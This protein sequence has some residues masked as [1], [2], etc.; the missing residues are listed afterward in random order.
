[1]PNKNEFVPYAMVSPGSE[2]V[3]SGQKRETVTDDTDEHGH[4]I[5]RWSLWTWTGVELEW[6]REIQ[7]INAMQQSLGPLDDET[8]RFRAHIASW[9][10]CDSGFPVTVDELLTAIGRG[11]LDEEPFHNG[12]F[13]SAG[14]KSTQPHQVESLRAIEEILRDYLAGKDVQDEVARF[15]YARGFIERAYQWLGPVDELSEVQRLLLQRVLLPFE[16]LTGRNPDQEAVHQ[17]CFGEDGLGAQLDAQ[18]A[19][20]AG[21]PR[22]HANYTREFK[23]SLATISDPAKRE[24]YKTCGALAHGLHGLSDCHHSTF[25]WTEG[26]IYATGTG[27]WDIPTRK[28]GA[29]RERLGRL[30]FGYVLGLDQW[31]KGTPMQFLLLDLGYV[32]LGFDPKNEILRVYALLGEERTPVKEWL[33]ACLW[34]LMYSSL[35]R[36]DIHK[37]LIER[38]RQAGV[39]L[40][41]WMDTVLAA[42]GQ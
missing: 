25:R 20:T 18:I 38:A 16:F 36:W 17:T 22:I 30:L 4:V 40:R 34:H 3:Y 33:V 28:R 35:M 31:L 15:P 39:S 42:G 2:A 14:T 8:R 29:E 7:H 19:A 21:L 10:H 27:K 26:W 41:E 5:R 23:E 37:E 9:A 13:W 12:C 11:K 24:L 1:M 32:D 6:G